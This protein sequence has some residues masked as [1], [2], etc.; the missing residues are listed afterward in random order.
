MCRLPATEEMKTVM[1]GE[2]GRGGEEE[3][4]LSQVYGVCS[5]TQI[6]NDYCMSTSFHVQEI[7]YVCLSNK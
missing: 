3:E 1:Q 4:M 7:K 6:T 2:G 5:C